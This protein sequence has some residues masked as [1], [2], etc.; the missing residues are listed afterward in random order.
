[1][2]VHNIKSRPHFIYLGILA[3]TFAYKGQV[4]F[5]PLE[6]YKSWLQNHRFSSKV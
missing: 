2:M 1:M 6:P 5:F 3:V 4:I